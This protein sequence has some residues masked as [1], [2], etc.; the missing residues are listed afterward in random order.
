MKESL[1]AMRESERVS[2]LDQA[3]YKRRRAIEVVKD[4]CADEPE[5]WLAK[6]SYLCEYISIFFHFETILE[7]LPRTA[8]WD[9]EK[10]YWLMDELL[11]SKMVLYIQ[12]VEICH[13]ELVNHNLSFSLH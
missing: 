6:F 9:E 12:S 3:L 4:L 13:E 1:F 8:T 5:D 11:A 7:N 10:N 2:Y